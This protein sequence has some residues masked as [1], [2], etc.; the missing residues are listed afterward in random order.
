[1]NPDKAGGFL[2]TTLTTV[3]GKKHEFEALQYHFHSPSEHTVNG[4]HV[5][6]EMHVVM[7]ANNNSEPVLPA[8]RGYGVLGFLF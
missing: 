8:E 4:N 5:D 3:Q 6:L 7:K 2:K 1:M